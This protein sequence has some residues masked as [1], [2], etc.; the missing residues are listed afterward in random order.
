MAARRARGRRAGPASCS[1]RDN[2]I[3]IDP[4]LLPHVFELFTQGDRTLDRSQGGLGVGLTVVE[5]LVALH[6]GRVEVTS[7]GIGKGSEFNV[8]LPCVSEVDFDAAPKADRMPLARPASASS[9]ST[10]T[11]MRRKPLPCS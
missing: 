5:R 2:G 8:A 9:S 6:H 1:V 11:P 4:E 10:T 7:D 3:G